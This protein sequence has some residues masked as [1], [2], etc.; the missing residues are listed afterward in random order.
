MIQDFAISTFQRKERLWI[1]IHSSVEEIQAWFSGTVFGEVAYE[2]LSTSFAT[3]V[4][5][6]RKGTS[7]DSSRDKLERVEGRA[8]ISFAFLPGN[9][10]VVLRRGMRGGL[11]R[12]VLKDSYLRPPGGEFRNV[13]EIFLLDDLYSAGVSVPRPLVALVS[14]SS[15]YRT[16]LGTERV[17]NAK[18]LFQ[19][20]REGSEESL[21]VSVSELAG[22]EARKTLEFGIFHPDL[23]PGNVLFDEERVFLIDFDKACRFSPSPAN[24]LRYRKGLVERFSRFC[25]K[26]G[27]YQ[28]SLSQGFSR[29][30]H[31]AVG[32]DE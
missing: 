20:A 5:I 29:G 14:G 12:P 28:Q 18:N 24:F 9:R 7:E 26:Y 4:D 22:K 23:H 30:L 3:L 21:L 10:E 15:C 27:I 13:E 19:M 1:R 11:L 8:K 32:V 31:D 16:F 2:D 6:F 25:R 17:K